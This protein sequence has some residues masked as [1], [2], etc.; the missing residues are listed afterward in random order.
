[1]C[2]RDS[3]SSILG[4]FQ[5]ALIRRLEFLCILKNLR[6]IFP[7]NDNN[8]VRIRKDNIARIYT[9]FTAGNRNIDFTR[10]FFIRAPRRGSGSINREIPDV[11]KRQV[12]VS[13][14]I[15]RTLSNTWVVAELSK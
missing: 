15:S 6:S 9:D 8:S 3:G 10:P 13:T 4:S 11:Y 14:M 7:W 2:I 5:L 1:M 12:I